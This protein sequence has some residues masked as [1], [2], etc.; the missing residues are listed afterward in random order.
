MTESAFSPIMKD[1]IQYN[2]DNVIEELFIIN[3]NQLDRSYKLMQLNTNKKRRAIN[4]NLLS[5][6][7]YVHFKT[8]F[9]QINKSR[10]TKAERQSLLELLSKFYAQQSV[11]V[12]NCD[13]MFINENMYISLLKSESKIAKNADLRNKLSAAYTEIQKKIQTEIEKIKTLSNTGFENVTES[14]IFNK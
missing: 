5:D 7:D 3:D 13:P 14:T 10:Y 8:L 1:M 4:S 6:G 11:I 9:T 2:M 12:L